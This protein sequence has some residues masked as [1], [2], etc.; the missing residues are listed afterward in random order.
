MSF[1]CTIC[2][3][4]ITGIYECLCCSLFIKSLINENITNKKK[5]KYEKINSDTEMEENIHFLIKKPDIGIKPNIGSEKDNDT[6]ITYDN[7]NITDFS[8]KSSLE[9]LYE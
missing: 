3:L 6:S 2:C 9:T 1:N 5:N 8:I 7:Y 4:T